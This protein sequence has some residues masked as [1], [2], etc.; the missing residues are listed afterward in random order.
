[1]ESKDLLL[2]GRMEM[3]SENLSNKDLVYFCLESG[4]VG[5]DQTRPELTISLSF[6]LIR[7]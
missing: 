4:K 6:F 5:R 3:V 1:M 7:R 2:F